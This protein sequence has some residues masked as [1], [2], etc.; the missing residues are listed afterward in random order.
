MKLW[1]S[2]L[3]CYCSQSWRRTHTL[4]ENLEEAKYSYREVE[5]QCVFCFSIFLHIFA[6][7][8]V[9]YFD[10]LNFLQAEELIGKPYGLFEV[11]SGKATPVALSKL[12][13]DG[14]VEIGT[15]YFVILFLY[16]VL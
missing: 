9:Y 13:E 14:A 11:V 12:L 16:F 3:L 5:S 15:N 6:L 7:S 8:E 2:G 4:D 10:S 1:I